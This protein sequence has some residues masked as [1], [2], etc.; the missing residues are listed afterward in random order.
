M[1]NLLS[2]SGLIIQRLI[3]AS[4]AEAVKIRPAPSAAHVA[5]HPLDGGVSV[6]FFDDVPEV[7]AG[8]QSQRGKSQA[9]QQFW[10]IIVS[11][12][13]VADAGNSA[14]QDAGVT[15]MQALVALQ[16]CKLSPEHG[17]LHRQ[18]SPYRATDDNGFVHL[19]MLFST[20]I[21]T[22]GGM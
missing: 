12:R 2:A 20:R 21:I 14:R 16:G 11:A 10:L 6:V 17:E 18:K 7:A 22:V 4:V 19:P 8:G 5:K 1:D 15:A 13:N 3:A 9:S